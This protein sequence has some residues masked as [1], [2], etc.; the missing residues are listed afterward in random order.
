MRL[1]VTMYVFKYH[2]TKSFQINHIRAPKIATTTMISRKDHMGFGNL[3]DPQ[4]IK[5]SNTSVIT[6]GKADLTRNHQCSR[7]ILTTVSSAC[8]PAKCHFLSLPKRR[9]CTPKREHPERQSSS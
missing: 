7:T 9:C 4:T 6:S 3:P 2:L 8:W 5:M 1:L